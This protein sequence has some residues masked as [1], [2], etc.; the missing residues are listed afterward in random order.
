MGIPATYEGSLHKILS[1]MSMCVI[2]DLAFDMRWL[3]QYHL[4]QRLKK[5]RSFLTKCVGV[6]YSILKINSK[7]LP[8]TALISSPCKTDMRFSVR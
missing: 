1:Y 6:F 7:F 4:L 5:L 8:Q 2:F 3:L